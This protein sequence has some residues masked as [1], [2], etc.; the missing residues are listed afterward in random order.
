MARRR[1]YQGIDAASEGEDDRPRRSAGRI[2]VRAVSGPSFKGRSQLVEFDPGAFRCSRLAAQLADEWVEYVEST[3]I[4]ASAASGY[5]RAI[6]RFCKAVDAELKGTGTEGDV[7]LASPLMF[8]LVAKWERGLSATYRAGSSWPAYLAGSLRTLIIRRDDHPDRATDTALARMAHGPLLVAWGEKNEHDEFS[9]KDKLTLVR[10]AWAAVNELESRLAAGW[11]LADQGKHPET[12][13]WL[14]LPDLLWGLARGQISPKD[15]TSRLPAPSAWPQDLRELAMRPD[16]SIP[17]TAA[18]QILA[19]RL[20]AWLYP[21]TL[22]LH[23]FRVLLVDATGCT[24]EEVTRFGAKDV[25]FLPKGV[26]L[27][28][29]R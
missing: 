26:R 17:A 7:D 3:G 1:D 16:G 27:T 11:H 4:T 18:G 9:R 24:S 20:V 13:S 19:R 22:D 28:V 25:E 10:A 8:R 2:G 5:R 12:G 6:D 15:I 23:A 14:C 29:V 21:T